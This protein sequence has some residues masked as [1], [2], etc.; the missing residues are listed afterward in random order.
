MTFLKIFEQNLHTYHRND[1]TSVCIVHFNYIL[2]LEDVI[3][4]HVG[5]GAV[6]FGPHCRSMLMQ[7]TKKSKLVHACRNYS[8]LKL[9]RFF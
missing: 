1:F 8:L 5:G 7:F 4:S 2:M 6:F 9:A 3:G